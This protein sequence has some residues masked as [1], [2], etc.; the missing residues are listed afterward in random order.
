MKSFFK[1]QVF[2]L[3]IMFLLL[4][5]LTL[6]QSHSSRI[7]TNGLLENYIDL[8]ERQ[9]SCQK[10]LALFKGFRGKL[11]LQTKNCFCDPI[12]ADYYDCCADSEYSTLTNATELEAPKYEAVFECLGINYVMHQKSDRRMDFY[13]FNKC[14]SVDDSRTELSLETINNCEINSSNFDLDVCLIF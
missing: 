4:C 9:D 2:V 14:P 5:D 6:F 10:D 1:F 12:C 13:V 3:K 8:K 7:L 11:T